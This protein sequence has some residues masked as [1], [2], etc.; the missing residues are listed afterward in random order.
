[1]L[2]L[3]V[4]L[5]MTA[6]GQAGVI[7][8]GGDDLTD[9]GFRNAAGT[10]IEG[11]LYIEKAI[12]NI[13]ASPFLTRPGA[14]MGGEIAALGS[15][16]PGAAFPGSNA[17]AAIKSAATNLGLN[18][19]FHE[20]ATAISDFFSALAGGTVNPRILYLPGTGAGN[21][22]D[23]TEGAAL[24]ANAAAIN[25]FVASGGGLM[26]HGSG[27]T[28]YG[29]LSALIPGL[30]DSGFCDASGAQLTAAGQAAFP[31][32]TNNDINSNAGPCHSSFVGPLGG[33][34]VFAFDGNSR[35]FIIGNAGPG[36]SV[37]E[38][39]AVPEPFT[40]LMLGSGLLAVAI[41]RKR[42]AA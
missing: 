30:S 16:D 28:A 9:H 37:T 41:A 35:P 8:L 13:A 12:G 26:S 18:V 4:F 7:I 40:S 14:V 20:G 19:G 22:L 15:A 5:A 31:G 21:D 23:S 1:M 39:P 32:L 25:N 17:G 33:M 6:S 34:T 10:N 2:T 36:G 3:L 24:T 27:S 42:R 38:P 11:W 29:W